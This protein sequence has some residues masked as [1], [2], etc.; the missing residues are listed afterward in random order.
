M[1][2]QASREDDC[3]RL[4]SAGGGVGTTMTAKSSTSFDRA[5]SPASRE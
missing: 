4:H 1:K 3:F 2:S 5:S